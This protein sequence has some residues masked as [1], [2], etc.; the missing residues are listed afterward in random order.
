MSLLREVAGD[1]VTICYNELESFLANFSQI[2][3][4][5]VGKRLENSWLEQ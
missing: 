2:F 5:T 4:Q 1:Q 3:G